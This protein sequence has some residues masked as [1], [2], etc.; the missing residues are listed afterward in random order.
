MAHIVVHESEVE[1]DHPTLVEGFPGIGLVG[2]IVVDY[3]LD[4]F[5]M[6]HFATMRCPGLSPVAIYR[7]GDRVVR[8]PVRIYADGERDLLALQSDIPVSPS[9]VGDFAS[10]LTG[11]LAEQEATGLYVS[12]TPA[13][14][15]TG[16]TRALTGVETPASVGMLEAHDIAPPVD[17]GI[18]SGP[19]GALLNQ[20]V[21]MELP[22]VGMIVESD[23][24]LPDPEAACTVL[25]EAIGPMADI[26]VD[27]DAVRERAEEIRTEHEAFARQMNQS[28]Q[29]D[30]SRAEPMRMYW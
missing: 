29:D 11:W 20:A 24:N 22:A 30:S 27:L 28:A 16:G 7:G 25:E 23:P 1:L 15:T 26:P 8:Q 6:D 17:D 13:E 19:T 9:V 4:A 12:G 2:K 3:L 18:W 21:D 5:E 14:V 10:C